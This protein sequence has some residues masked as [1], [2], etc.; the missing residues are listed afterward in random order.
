MAE[1]RSPFDA[2]PNSQPSE[3]A[4]RFG[5]AESAVVVAHAMG[6]WSDRCNRAFRHR[7]AT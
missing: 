1:Q 7:G 3:A 5:T 4:T 6:G 2:N